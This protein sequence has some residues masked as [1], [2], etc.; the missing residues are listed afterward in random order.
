MTLEEIG[1]Y[2]IWIA[3]MPH[4][5]IHFSIGTILKQLSKK[6]DLNSKDLEKLLEVIADN[7]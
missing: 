2:L 1:Q 7:D 4:E 3:T 5:N 6:K